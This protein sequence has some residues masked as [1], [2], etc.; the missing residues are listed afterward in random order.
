MEAQEGQSAKI[1]EQAYSRILPL[2]W[3]PCENSD[4]LYKQ[5]SNV[6]PLLFLF[7]SGCE[8]N[9]AIKLLKINT[10]IRKENGI[11][12]LSHTDLKIMRSEICMCF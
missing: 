10:S 11:G 2:H 3:K 6:Y 5:I 12:A 7:S 9:L 8:S 4:G 1:M